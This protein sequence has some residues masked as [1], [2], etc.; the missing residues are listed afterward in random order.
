MV[1]TGFDT[2]F[3]CGADF[4]ARVRGFIQLQMERWPRFLFNEEE[5]STAG[6]A[7]WTLPDTRG[8]K[9]PDILTFCKNAG[10]N[11]FWEENGYALDASGE[12][13]FALFFRLH[14]DTL[15]AEELTG[16]RQT[17]PADEDPYRLEGSSLLLTEYYTATLVTPENPREDPFSRSVVQDFLKSFGSDAFGLTHTM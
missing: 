9:Y 12:G 14:S 5:L 7:S 2:T 16:A 6:L 10:M 1:P 8:E 13:P 4:P 15:Y 17:V 3:I 11:D